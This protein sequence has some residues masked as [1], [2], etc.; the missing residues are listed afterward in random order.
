MEDGS[1]EKTSVLVAGSMETVKG[2]G[3]EKNKNDQL[4]AVLGMESP[5]L[6]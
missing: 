5:A 4:A 1:T 2:T 3:G 6:T